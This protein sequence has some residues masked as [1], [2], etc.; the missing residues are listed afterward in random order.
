[1][2]VLFKQHPADDYSPTFESPYSPQTLVSDPGLQNQSNQATDANQYPF[3]SRH[4]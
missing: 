4:E 2:Y 1:M 3:R